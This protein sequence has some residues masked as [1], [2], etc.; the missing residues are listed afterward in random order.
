MIGTLEERLTALGTEK[1]QLEAE[2]SALRSRVSELE[3]LTVGGRPCCR[4]TAAE[5]QLEKAASELHLYG[6]VR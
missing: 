4:R 6:E 3:R 1:A 5:A 2:N